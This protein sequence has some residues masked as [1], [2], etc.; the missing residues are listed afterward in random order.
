MTVPFQNGLTPDHDLASFPPARCEPDHEANP[1]GTSPFCR[2]LSANR[3]RGGAPRFA[4]C[5]VVFSGQDRLRTIKIPEEAMLGLVF[6]GERELELMQ[7]PDPSPDAHDVVIEM[8]ASG[9]C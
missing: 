3:S 4:L 1:G 8:K 7:F 9:M 5:G 6:H 2:S